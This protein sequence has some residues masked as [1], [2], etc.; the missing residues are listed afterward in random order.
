MIPT[1]VRNAQTGDLRLNETLSVSLDSGSLIM[2]D[3]QAGVGQ[4]GCGYE[5]QLETPK[6]L[7]QRNRAYTEFKAA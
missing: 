5:S 2:C 6:G 7:E 1:Y 4:T 3:G